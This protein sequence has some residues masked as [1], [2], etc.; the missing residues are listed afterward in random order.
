MKRDP[1]VLGEGCILPGDE[2][3]K[4]RPNGN[5]LIVGT[6][7]C[8]KSTSVVLPTLML[9]EHS[10]PIISCG[11]EREGYT[12]ARYLETKGYMVRMMNLNHPD[13][14]TISFDPIQSMQGYEDIEALAAA[15]MDEAFG[16][17]DN[18][19]KAKAGQLLNSLI[20]AVL[21]A[22][23]GILGT[24]VRVNMPAVLGFFD[25]LIP[26]ERENGH[27]VKTPLDSLFEQLEEAVRGC[28]A[29]R[30]YRAWRN[31]PCEAAAR[32]RDILASAL[33]TVFPESI[34]KMMAAKPRFHVKNFADSKEAL[35]IIASPSDHSRQHYANLFYR[36]TVRQLL[37][38]A[39]ECPDGELPREVRFI[40]DP[41][42]CNAPIQGWAEDMGLF[43]SA[44]ISAVM[45][46][47]SD[48]Q[49]EAVYKEEA[50]RIRQNCA[51]YCYFP[52]GFDYKSCE[53][54]SRCMG[55][56]CEEMFYAPLNQV[57]IMQSGRRPVHIPRYSVPG[58]EEYEIYINISKTVSIR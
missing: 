6:G 8:G 9:S 57:F 15:V 21:M 22:A 53:S 32:I 52:G 43:H 35:I 44:G 3:G 55:R 56:S 36:D 24:A 4:T 27:S 17:E 13:K 23:E 18:Y 30:E 12:I 41:F 11:R 47:Q 39:A 42:A 40:F 19:E 37:Q 34:R 29:S 48:Q 45:L 28:S 49:L 46:L 51:V 20:A 54:I 10:N 50:S 7:G 5:A 38:Y 58:S 14:S 31:L 1:L 25:Q 33:S 26:V 16:K 2:I